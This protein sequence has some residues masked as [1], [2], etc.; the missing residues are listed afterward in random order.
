MLF[1][2]QPKMR[3]EDLYDREEELKEFS[4]AVELGETLVLLLGI[5]RLGKSSLLN[6][7]LSES[8][9]PFS[10]IDVRSLYFTHGSIPQELL[11]RKLLE[12]LLKSLKGRDKL[13]I[14]LVNALSRVKGVKISGIQ[15]EFDEKPDLSELLERL[16]AWA[17]KTGKRVIIAF[18]EAQY[19]RLSGIQYDGLIAYAVDNLPN[20]TFVLTGSEVGMLHDF[21]GLDNPR[22]PLFGRYAREIT[23]KRF[24]REQSG[25]F[26]RRGF[27]ELG[28]K[29]HEEEIERVVEKLDGIVGWLTLYGYLRGVRKL[30]EKDALDEL[31]ERAKALVLDEISTLTRYS[32]RYWYLLKAVSLG[33]DSWS[34]IK[35]YVEFKAGKIN[36]AKFSALLKNLVKYGY[37]EKTS[38]GYS[39][40]D[41]VVREVIKKTNLPPGK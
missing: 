23:L 17:E 12:G 31:F 2:L 3:R 36:D 25:D 22:K 19:L 15:V 5:R 1:D 38:D 37:L 26:L 8:G 14:G 35:E 30:P 29:V 20:L 40:P 41:P 27:D 4:E 9:K 33:N 11:A 6:V 10:K 21:I 18:D 16:D 34:S 13:R 24:S 7:A 32:A 28:V 39:I